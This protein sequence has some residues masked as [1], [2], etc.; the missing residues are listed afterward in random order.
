MFFDVLASC[1][2]MVVSAPKKNNVCPSCHRRS[3]ENRHETTNSLSIIQTQALHRIHFVGLLRRM[4]SSPK[5]RCPRPAQS[6]WSNVCGTTFAIE[7]TIWQLGQHLFW[8]KGYL[9]FL[10]YWSCWSL[11]LFAAWFRFLYPGFLFRHFLVISM[12]TT[13]IALLKW[14][15]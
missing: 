2:T 12:Q 13:F 7:I 4:V 15:F 1:V 8:C 3:C 5:S 14:S 11:W 9:I 6:P 10:T